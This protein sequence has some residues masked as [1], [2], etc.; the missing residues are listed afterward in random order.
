MKTTYTRWHYAGAAVV[1]LA[2][3]VQVLPDFESAP[4]VG[5]SKFLL[6]LVLYLLMSFVPKNVLEEKYTKQYDMDVWFFRAWEAIIQV[7]IGGLLVPL[8][9]VKVGDQSAIQ[10]NQ[11]GTYM[12]F[13]FR[14]FLG[15]KSAAAMDPSN[16]LEGQCES[17]W[18][19]WIFFTCANVLHDVSSIAIAKYS[20]AAMGSLWGSTSVIL[21]IFLMQFP[22]LSGQP[23]QPI[24]F[25][26]LGSVLLIVAGLWMYGRYPE[27][28][29]QRELSLDRR[30]SKSLGQ[31]LL[32][33]ASTADEFDY[34]TTSTE[35][36]SDEHRS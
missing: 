11:F 2:S 23:R 27:E 16:V 15:D 8:A 26:T 14:C 30:T 12:S 13:A 28:Q 21:T 19:V 24:S 1:V 18:M 34:R 20:S 22:E 10:P 36:V 3:V 17:P 35:M 6:G 7:C 25:Y 32:E 4:P 31:S 33:P 9:F 5:F 29:R